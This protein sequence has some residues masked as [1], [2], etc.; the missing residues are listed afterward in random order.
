MLY[1]S[2]VYEI[3]IYYLFLAFFFHFSGIIILEVKMKNLC[4]HIILLCDRDTEKKNTSNK[5]KQT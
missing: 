1:V 4:V 3:C 5:E 2:Y